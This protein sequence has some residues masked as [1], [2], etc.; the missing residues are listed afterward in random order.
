MIFLK[1]QKQS[2]ILNMN[3]RECM[4][5]HKPL[6]GRSDKKF[7]GDHCRSSYHNRLGNGYSRPV[8]TVNGILKSNRKIIHHLLNKNNEKIVSESTLKELGFKFDY[9]TKVIAKADAHEEFHCYEYVY[10]KTKGNKYNLA[11][12]NLNLSY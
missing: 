10:F 12:T 9:C 2:I 3:T 6:S 1:N 11:R 5:C 7:C 4:D 8:K